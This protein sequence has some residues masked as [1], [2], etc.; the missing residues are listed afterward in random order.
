MDDQPKFHR[1][2]DGCYVLLGPL[3]WRIGGPMVDHKVVIPAG[4]TFDSSVPRWHMTPVF[5]WPLAFTTGCWNKAMGARRR[6]P[7][8]MTARARAVRPMGWPAGPIWRW[9]HGRCSRHRAQRLPPNLI[10][11]PTAHSGR[12]KGVPPPFNTGNV[13]QAHPASQIKFMTAPNR[14]HGWDIWNDSRTNVYP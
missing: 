3:P 6:Q 8:G 11:N 12:S 1:C 10:R 5:C 13:S 4:F 7:N 2:I 14:D 9:R